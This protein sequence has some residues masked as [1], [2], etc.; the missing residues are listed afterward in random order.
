MDNWQFWNKIN[1]IS[2]LGQ[3]VNPKFSRDKELPVGLLCG[4][5]EWP[6]SGST[7]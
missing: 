4:K 1:F 3:C 7:K 6:D 5:D 2:K